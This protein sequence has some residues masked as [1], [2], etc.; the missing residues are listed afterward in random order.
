M[1]KKLKVIDDPYKI[2]AENFSKFQKWCMIKT[3]Q[4]DT[5]NDMIDKF[6]NLV[7]HIENKDVSNGLKEINNL[8]AN[9]FN[10][11]EKNNLNVE[12]LKFLVNTDDEDEA[13]DFLNKN[14]TK[15]EL[16]KLSIDVKKKFIRN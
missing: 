6:S 3:D 4:G 7:K 9:I 5:F 13:I 15:E 10:M 8:Y 12:A 14:Y 1:E 2:T 11:Y 16:E